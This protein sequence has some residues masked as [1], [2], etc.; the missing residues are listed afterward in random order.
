[1][2]A[3]AEVLPDLSAESAD[4]EVRVAGLAPA[5][6]ERPTPAPGWSIAHQIA[7]L[8]WTDQMALL[9]IDDPAQLRELGRRALGDG[10]NYVDQV[11]AEGAHQPPQ[12]LLDRWRA[13]R[14]ELAT[15]LAAVPDDR[16][17]DWFGPPMSATS[18]ATARL[19]ETWAHG[20]D[21]ADALG[22]S[23]P[24][25]AR[26]RH[27]ARLAVRTRDFAY[28][29]HDLPVPSE[30]FRVELT[31]PGAVVWVYGPEDARQR[32]T[33]SALDFCLLAAQRRHR[34]D[35]DLVA[36]GADAQRWLGIIQMFAGPPG[37][38]RERR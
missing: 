22:Q 28:V 11:A 12:Q 3:L 16:K 1:M 25:T 8:A 19:M 21:V 5:D 35:V 10:V 32:V 37:A 2:S 31:G 14:S 15:K 38:G 9:S 26:L 18:M 34:D 20:H 7:H 36:T 17:L 30:Q 33:G 29:L 6:W 24:V 4:L 13:G 27:I 23:V